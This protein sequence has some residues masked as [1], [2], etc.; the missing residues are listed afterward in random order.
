[1][2]SIQRDISQSMRGILVDWLVEVGVISTCAVK[3]IQFVLESLGRRI[4][5]I[6]NVPL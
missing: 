4:E 5:L 3:F 1:M 6:S 2:E